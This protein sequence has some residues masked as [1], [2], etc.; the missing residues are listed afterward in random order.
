[1]RYI[2]NLRAHEAHPAPDPIVLST[3][4]N[5]PAD[6]AATKGAFRAWCG[7]ESTQHIFLSANEGIA[8]NLRI[9]SDNPIHTCSGLICDFDSAADWA[10]IETQISRVCPYQPTY[11]ARSYSD[12]VRVIWLFEEPVPIHPEFFPVFAKELGHSLAVEK[13]TYGFDPASYRAEQY[14]EIGRDWKLL[15]GFL[16]KS[17]V[18]GH[19]CKASAK[20]RIADSDVHIPI[21]EIAEEVHRQFPGRWPK[22]F[23]V[24]SRGPLFWIDDGKND[25]AC[26]I[27]EDGVTAFSTRAGKGF[28]S[29]R[30]ILGDKFVRDYETKKLAPLLD[31]YWFDGKTFLKLSPEGV[32]I[33]VNERQVSR[34][35]RQRGFSQK[36]RKSEPLSEVESALLTI[37]NVNRVDAVA[38]LLFEKDRI[39]TYNSIRILNSAQLRPV[40][41]ADDGDPAF[42]PFIHNWLQQLFEPADPAHAPAGITTFDYFISWAARI[43]QSVIARYPAQGQAL[44]LV[45]PTGR[46]KTLLSNKV[47][48]GLLG[49]YADASEYLA[50][51]TTFNKKLC[52]LPLW[53]IDDTVSA[54]SFQDQRKAA[55]L[56]K[57]TVANPKVEYHAKHENAVDLPWTG[58]AVMTMN[59]DPNSLSMVPSLD[60]SNRDKIIAIRIRDG[61]TSSFPDNHVVEATI[62][63]ELPHFARFLVEWKT[64]DPIRGNSRFGVASYID[65]AIV[66]AA[67]D[68]GPRAS[69]A[70]LVDWFV[71]QVR[72]DIPSS[73]FWQGTL[74]EFQTAVL[75]YNDGRHLGHSFN[76]EF[77]R[78][79]VAAMEESFKQEPGKHRP[80][81]SHGDGGGKVWAISL[82]P[83]FDLSV[84]FSFPATSPESKE[85][86]ISPSSDEASEAPSAVE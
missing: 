75:R 33:V 27:R 52:G 81:M 25:E 68:N 32:P 61:A 55:E 3:T 53:V 19:V 23:A 21:A 73:L 30:E 42:W 13:V 6:A 38:P 43:Y 49:G 58:R 71:K 28:F 10:T 50:G 48:G 1:M 69:I 37:Q 60:S 85:P 65:P 2:A 24:G 26:V 35:L 20:S 66:A 44:L 36:A 59:M 74:T 70:E 64:P 78:R 47:L 8:P 51:K 22:D 11:L 39:A 86:A 80:V 84:S 54:A 12:G 77:V 79:G 41:P 5:V 9:S 34:E 46:G 17:L 56:L 67:F 57:R 7:Q 4:V 62:A 14:F 16:P 15:G 31:E 40:L 45:G 18:N 63:R 82:D 83:G 29:W 72:V 76:M